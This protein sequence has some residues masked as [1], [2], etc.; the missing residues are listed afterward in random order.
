MKCYSFRRKNKESYEQL[1]NQKVMDVSTQRSAQSVSK[2]D[3]LT[4]FIHTMSRSQRD[5]IDRRFAEALIKDGMAFSACQSKNWEPFWSAVFGD[6]YRPPKKDA[7]S[8]KFL[9]NTFTTTREECIAYMA[10]LRSLCVS[11]DG[12]TDVT[13]K[14]VF[15]YLVGAPI[16]L[17][18]SSFRL[19]SKRESALN[20]DDLLHKTFTS[21]QESIPNFE[22]VYGLVTDSPNVMVKARRLACGEERDGSNHVVFGYGCS[23]HAL[24]LFTKDVLKLGSVRP[25]FKQ[26][27]TVASYFK[28]THLA[29][30]ELTKARELCSRRSVTIKTFSKTRWNGVS[31]ML[32]SILINKL[33]IT[34]VMNNEKL[35][36]PKDALLNV[37]TPTD[38]AAEVYSITH[39][40]F[41]WSSLEKFV[42]MFN[43][44]TAVITFLESDLCA[45]SFIP[46]AF[47][48][49]KEAC[50]C[51]L[52]GL[53]IIEATQYLKSRFT[54]IASPVFF[55]AMVLDPLIPTERLGAVG[56]L[57]GDETLIGAASTALDKDCAYVNLLMNDQVTLRRLLVLWLG[58]PKRYDSKA[59]AYHPLAWWKANGFTRSSQL[60]PVAT[61]VFG[62]F[63]SSAGP[64]R[65]F[66][67]RSRV[68][69]KRRNRL[70]SDHADMQSAIIY[71]SG[72]MSRIGSGVEA[73]ER[74]SFVENMMIEGF[75]SYQ[76][77]H[78][79]SNWG[80][81]PSIGFDVDGSDMSKE[82]ESFEAELDES[83]STLPAN[84]DIWLKAADAL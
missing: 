82:M 51:F 54:R 63:S 34:T 36:L 17:H 79:I 23:C 83:L 70:L 49:L 33:A 44:I 40:P 5:T 55:L 9:L 58:S 29:N 59:S 8:N 52:E 50:E 78:G 65:S 13:S 66:K 12:F 43:V 61:R 46:L 16:P 74:K 28:T 26:A 24:S 42:P 4:P 69:D 77:S 67:V 81:L 47:S 11:V 84:V 64:E 35:K 19:G 1:R 18:V 21:L 39:S 62:L 2:H 15:N 73:S 14:S 30:V 31:E 7:V 20:V 76:S 22:K 68:H 37:H 41:F 38:K 3:A 6:I 75:K 45:V 72:Q 48:V 57:L 32:S 53:E 71:N 80:S 56:W 25:L 27:V 60:A 10:S